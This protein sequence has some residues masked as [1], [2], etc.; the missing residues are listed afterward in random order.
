MLVAV[1]TVSAMENTTDDVGNFDGQNEVM[2]A[3]DEDLSLYNGNE[4]SIASDTKQNISHNIIDDDLE[5][6]S[7]LK[8]TAE[9][10]LKNGSN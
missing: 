10:S 4:I 3:S 9:D 5:G 8:S 2:M 7:I 1:S 6:Q